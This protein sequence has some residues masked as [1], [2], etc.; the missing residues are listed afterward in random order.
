MLKK[1]KFVQFGANLTQFSSN[2]EMVLLRRRAKHLV[3]LSPSLDEEAVWLN[4]K[5]E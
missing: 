1:P 2:S 5:T 3:S 4:D